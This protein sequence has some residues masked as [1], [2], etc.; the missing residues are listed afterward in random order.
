MTG[1]S[2]PNSIVS[3]AYVYERDG[4][5]VAKETWSIETLPNG[6]QQ[7][8]S[9]RDAS[10][11]GAQIYV[12]AKLGIGGDGDYRFVWQGTL[13]RQWVRSTAYRLRGNKISCRSKPFGTIQVRGGEATVFFPL[14]RVFTG[15]AVLATIERGGAAIWVVPDISDPKEK[16]TLFS[17]SFSQRTITSEDGYYR[18][19]GGPYK[20]PVRIILRPDGLLDHYEFTSQDGKDYWVCRYVSSQA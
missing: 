11:F 12:E 10:Q 14:M 18:L 17:P 8:K 1:D 19:F 5:V 3:G 16:T 6:T 20:T 9:R 13:D 7:I 15:N 2:D 4:I